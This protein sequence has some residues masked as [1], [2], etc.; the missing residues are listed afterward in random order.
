[1]HEDVVE[2]YSE[3][4]GEDEWQEIAKFQALKE[5]AIILEDKR[6]KKRL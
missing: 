1:M 4:S 2:K 3:L 6:K 5:K